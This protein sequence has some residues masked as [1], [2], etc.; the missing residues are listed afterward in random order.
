MNFV[1]Q[2][3]NITKAIAI[4]FILTLLGEGLFAFGWYWPALILFSDR[5]EIFWMALVLGLVVGSI[6]GLPIGVPSLFLL[7][8]CGLVSLF[9]D[10]KKIGGMVQVVLVVVAN[11]VFDKVFNIN[12]SVFELI[13]VV[14]VFVMFLKWFESQDSIRL[15][16]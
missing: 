11:I 15:R 10:I 14:L 5:E 16:Y 9:P 7:I 3:K 6:H 1:D 2:D 4:T 13:S 8:V 12:W